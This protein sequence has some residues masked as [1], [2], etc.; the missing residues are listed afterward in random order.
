[1]LSVTMYPHPI[2][3][4]YTVLKYFKKTSPRNKGY[5]DLDTWRLMYYLHI[6]QCIFLIVSK[7]KKIMF[8]YEIVTTIIQ[9]CFIKG[10]FSKYHLPFF[11][12]KKI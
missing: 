2:Y 10:N 11:K 9:T 1:M 8:L 4:V 6:T 12:G 3:I 5:R 7:R